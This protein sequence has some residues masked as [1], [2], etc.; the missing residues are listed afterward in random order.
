MIARIR[1]HTAENPAETKSATRE[2]RPCHA[3]LNSR[4]AF[5][6]GG[7]TFFFGFMNPVPNGERF[8]FS[9]LPR[10]QKVAIIG[11]QVRQMV[12]PVTQIGSGSLNRPVL[13]AFD[14]LVAAFSGEAT[15]EQLQAATEYLLDAIKAERKQEGR[16]RMAPGVNR[17]K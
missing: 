16:S 17:R 5:V 9:V 10:C 2:H 13:A 12:T 15:L 1:N 7:V 6:R 4:S 11:Q 14:E 3:R 8:E